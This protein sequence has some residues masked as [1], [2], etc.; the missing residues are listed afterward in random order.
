[1]TV[2]KYVIMR[3]KNLLCADTRAES[4]VSLAAIYFMFF[5]IHVFLTDLK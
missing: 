1:M 5:N 3:N 4:F 2:T